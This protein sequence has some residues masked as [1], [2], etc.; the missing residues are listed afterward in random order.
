LAREVTYYCEGPDCNIHV[1]STAPAPVRGW[2]LVQEPQDDG[3]AKN[4]DLCGWT[5]A[6][7]LA[8]GIDPE[9]VIEVEAL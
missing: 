8:A 5:C 3:T 1:R 6:L 9:E 4:I 2:L 7:R